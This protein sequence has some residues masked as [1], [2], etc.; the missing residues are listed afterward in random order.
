MSTTA[1]S[2]SLLGV[3][4]SSSTSSTTSSSTSDFI[5]LLLKELENQDPTD[6]MDTSEL[7]SQFSTL[8]QVQQGETMIEYLDTL[9]Q[10]SSSV[11]SAQ[12]ISCIGKT[13]TADTSSIT[14]SNGISETFNFNL[15]EDAS[16]ATITIYDEDGN[17]V[18][19]L[20]C[21]DLSSGSVSVTWDGTDSNGD[22]VDDGT[23]T[24]EVAASDA[25]GNSVTASTSITAA[26]TGVLYSGGTAYLVTSDGSQ[27]AY[28]DVTAVSST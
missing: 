7:V 10:Y 25:D 11:N 13:V 27:I 8:T 24:F 18:T 4:S 12:A 28:G 14:V 5:T 26:I 15:S 9:T 21:E 2:S 3:A 17:E 19:T 20:S 22:T 23:Y 6:P 16:E 1:I